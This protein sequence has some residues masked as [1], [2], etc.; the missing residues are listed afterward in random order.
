MGKYPV[1]RVCQ[2]GE[3]AS[4]S[5]QWLRHK[6]QFKDVNVS[7]A[8]FIAGDDQLDATAKGKT[9]PFSTCN[10]QHLSQ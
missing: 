5:T 3:S 9:K 10:G 6:C 7:E 1:P 4:Y 2:C 8:N